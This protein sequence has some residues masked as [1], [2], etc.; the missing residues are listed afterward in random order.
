MEKTDLLDFPCEYPL[1]VMGHSRDEFEIAVLTII[2]QHFGELTENAIASKPS[3][4]GKYLAMT[5]TVE[6]TSQE[7]IDNANQALAANEHVVM[8]L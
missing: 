8:V 7:Q 3:K 5:I 4:N 2:R 1:K 6:A